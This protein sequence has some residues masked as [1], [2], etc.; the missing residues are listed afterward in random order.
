MSF[1]FVKQITPGQKFLLNQEK[2]FDQNLCKSLLHYLIEYDN[3]MCDWFDFDKRL[4]DD[5]TVDDIYCYNY[6]E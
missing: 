4:F 6:R 3:Q 1:L 5:S 2:Y